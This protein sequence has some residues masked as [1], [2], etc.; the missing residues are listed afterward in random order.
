[1][2][3]SNEPTSSSIQSPDRR[4]EE[5]EQLLTQLTEASSE[6]RMSHAERKFF[7]DMV[8]RFEEYDDRT[9]VSERQVWWLRDLCEK[10]T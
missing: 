2:S 3:P 4:R 7:H 8:D 5:A 1:M 10:Y 6:L 9:M